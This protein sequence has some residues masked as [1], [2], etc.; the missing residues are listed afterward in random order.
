MEMF[1][2]W[3]LSQAVTHS[4]VKT[5]EVAPVWCST[6]T[7]SQWA[8]SQELPGRCPREL[9]SAVQVMT[10][11]DKVW[12]INNVPKNTN[13]A[14]HCLSCG[15]LLTAGLA[16]SVK[17]QVHAESGMKPEHLAQHHI[18]LVIPNGPPELTSVSPQQSQRSKTSP[19][20][21]QAELKEPRKHFCNFM[22]SREAHLPLE[23]KAKWTDRPNRSR[24]FPLTSTFPT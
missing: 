2:A 8:E 3:N 16:L 12:S 17:I 5:Y 7:G 18:N 24:D 15:L 22:N 4:E 6:S 23:E 10:F 11:V 14:W 19:E 9:A 13:T 21:Q 20:L 1:L